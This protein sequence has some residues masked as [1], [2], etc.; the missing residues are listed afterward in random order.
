MRKYNKV[1]AENQNTDLEDGKMLHR[2]ES[3]CRAAIQVSIDLS[4]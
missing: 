4:V 2:A 1:V 3:D